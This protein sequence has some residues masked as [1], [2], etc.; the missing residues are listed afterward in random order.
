[1]ILLGAACV[2]GCPLRWLVIGYAGCC[3]G[4]RW[5]GFCM[6]RGSCRRRGYC[7]SI[8]VTPITHRCKVISTPITGTTAWCFFSSLPQSAVQVP[9][10]CGGSH[11]AGSRTLA[12]SN[13][14]TARTHLCCRSRLRCCPAAVGM[15]SCSHIRSGCTA[16]QGSRRSDVTCAGRLC[17]ASSSLSPSRSGGLGIESGLALHQCRQHQLRLKE[18]LLAIIAGGVRRHHQRLPG[19]VE[20]DGHVRVHCLA[21]GYHGFQVPHIECGVAGGASTVCKV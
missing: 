5:L 16:H 6:C 2:L 14:C 9:A 20:G 19:R 18:I 13:R 15:P 17:S 4:E 7:N 11:A 3:K 8:A 12:T 1:M 21:K 10:G